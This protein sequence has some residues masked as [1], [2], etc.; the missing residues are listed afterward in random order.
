MRGVLGED[1]IVGLSLMELLA[2]D[3]SV[4]GSVLVLDL[5]C[6]EM[7]D[8]L[9]SAEGCVD[10]LTDLGLESLSSGTVYSVVELL[11]LKQFVHVHVSSLFPS[12]LNSVV[13]IPRQS[14]CSH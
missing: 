11:G 5:V 7:S 3:W 8:R 9:S 12:R 1:A 4:S 13:D 2:N 10:I 14:L 6:S